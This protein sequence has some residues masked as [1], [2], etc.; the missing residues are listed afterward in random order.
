[1]G[2]YAEDK[3]KFF[4]FY[5]TTN[6]GKFCG[7]V[8]KITTSNSYRTVVMAVSYTHLD[9]Y[10]RQ[11]DDTETFS[12]KGVVPG[13][14]TS[15]PSKF[16]CVVLNMHFTR[17]MKIPRSSRHW[18]TGASG[19]SVR[20]TSWKQL[21]CRIDRCSRSLLNL[22]ILCHVCATLHDL[23]LMNANSIKMHINVV[24]TVRRRGAV[25]YTHLAR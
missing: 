19:C 20:C 24:R 18:N 10:K 14:E 9:V 4:F 1:M 2:D 7:V 16:T 25:S 6:S 3:D 15:K 11:V 13:P 5:S 22:V 8:C 21:K 23:E 17:L 12:T